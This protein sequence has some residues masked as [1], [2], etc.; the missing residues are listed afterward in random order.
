M[1][2]SS[3]LVYSLV[4]EPTG[5]HQHT[6]KRPPL[7]VIP[8]NILPGGAIIKKIPVTGGSEQLPIV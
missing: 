4:V 1:G 6:K 5:R 3:G 8:K 2:A 7:A